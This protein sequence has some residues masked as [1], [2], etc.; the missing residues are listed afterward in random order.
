MIGKGLRSF[1]Q[2]LAKK[3]PDTLGKDNQ[4]VYKVECLGSCRLFDIALK[5]DTGDADLYIR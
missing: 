1:Y 3:L 5:V 2:L 4:T